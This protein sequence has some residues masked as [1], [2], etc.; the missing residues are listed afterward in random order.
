MFVLSWV[1]AFVNPVTR[2]VMGESTF[3]TDAA[4]K[5]II[6]ARCGMVFASTF[7][8]FLYLSYAVLDAKK[9]HELAES[10]A[11][12]YGDPEIRGKRLL[13]SQVTAV[14]CAGSA[15]ICAVETSWNGRKRRAHCAVA[16]HASVFERLKC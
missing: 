3:G 1:Y 7:P 4:S 8:L 5:G 9:R 16:A 11:A 14:C 12:S 6:G 2:A 15:W 13:R 10:L